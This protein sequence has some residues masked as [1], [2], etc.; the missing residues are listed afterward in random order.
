MRA[1]NLLKERH[2]NLKVEPNSVKTS[3]LIPRLLKKF[4]YCAILNTAEQEEW[5]IFIGS[6]SLSSF[7]HNC[8]Y[9]NPGPQG[10]DGFF[11]PTPS[12]YRPGVH[13]KQSPRFLP[14][15]IFLYV[16]FGHSSPATLPFIQK[17]PAGH[18]K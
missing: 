6:P 12:Q 2:L 11:R 4:I 8:V 3:L 15:V 17:L 13:T 9:T 16:P 10:P 14:P 1:P 7:G 5:I 18:V